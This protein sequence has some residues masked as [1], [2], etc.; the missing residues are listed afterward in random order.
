MNLF[1]ATSFHCQRTIENK[2]TTAFVLYVLA[3]EFRVR[4]VRLKYYSSVVTPNLWPSINT[5]KK[6][7][8][9]LPESS[10][11]RQNLKSLVTAH[12]IIWDLSNTSE[13]NPL[14]FIQVSTPPKYLQIAWWLI[15]P[16][17]MNC[18]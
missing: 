4:T 2:H 1:E 6:K 14:I 11:F 13:N 7:M 9:Y 15:L 16:S 5:R 17:S 12:Y 10:R 3:V 8:I 18:M